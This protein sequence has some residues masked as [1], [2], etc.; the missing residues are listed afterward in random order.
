MSYYKKIRKTWK[1]KG[2]ILK[3]KYEEIFTVE[4]NGYRI[5]IR[6]NARYFVVKI[7]KV[8]MKDFQKKAQSKHCDDQE[9]LKSHLQQICSFNSIDYEGLENK[10]FKALKPSKQ[11][12]VLSLKDTGVGYGEIHQYV[13]SRFW[14]D[15]E[16][17]LKNTPKLKITFNE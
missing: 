6:K 1:K 2:N 8:K 16:K 4:E 7:G 5:Q 14:E 13:Q 11:V 15:T 9:S 3:K 17:M 10:L 12:K